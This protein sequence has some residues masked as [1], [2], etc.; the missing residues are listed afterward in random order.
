MLGPTIIAGH[1][2]FPKQVG[3]N[4]LPFRVLLQVP[5]IN[6]WTTHKTIRLWVFL[7]HTDKFFQA[8]SELG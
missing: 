5:A 6:T 2:T 3:V 1:E 8:R 7:S 4:D